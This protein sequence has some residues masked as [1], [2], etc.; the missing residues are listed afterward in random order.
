MWK[1]EEFLASY[2]IRN[3]KKNNSKQ[4][5][6][7]IVKIGTNIKQNTTKTWSKM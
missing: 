3:F 5:R 4:S 6:R 1:L 7:K 2:N